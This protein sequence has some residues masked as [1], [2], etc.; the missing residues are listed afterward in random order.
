MLNEVVERS[1][2]P[3]R[4]RVVNGRLRNRVIS[5]NVEVPLH[6]A[7]EEESHVVP[8]YYYAGFWL[9]FWA[10]LLDMLVV[11]SLNGLLVYPLLR[12]T[13]VDG[14]LSIASFSFESVLTAIVF[15]LYFAIMTK[16]YG[17]TI[18]KMVLGI[19][20]I[21]LNSQELN[22][23]QI[24]FREGIGRFIHQAFFLLYAIYTMVA[25]TQKK[26][27]LHDIIADTIVIHERDEIKKE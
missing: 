11:F 6:V 16:L 24:I 17:Q 5:Q 4:K 23:T 10:F 20:V 9:R 19:R 18:G 26:Q 8:T 25:F 22:W 13:G 3:K 15:F 1:W 2:L 7:Q 27:G 21:S 12:V 14:L